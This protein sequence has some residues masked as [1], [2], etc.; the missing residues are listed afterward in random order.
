MII[1]SILDRKDNAEYKGIDKYNAKQFY[2]EC[3]HYNTI[4]EG[5]ADNIT[6]AMDY[7]TEEDVKKALCDYVIGNGYNIAICDFI[8]SVNWL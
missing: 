5:V 6:K 7:G 4:F 3:M 1:D 2:S 8:N